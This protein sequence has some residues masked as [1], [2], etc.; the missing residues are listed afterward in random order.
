MMNGEKPVVP[1]NY[2]CALIARACSFGRK[3]PTAYENP[4]RMDSKRPLP[5]MDGYELAARLRGDLGLP[6]LPVI[7]LTGWGS[8]QDRARTTAAGF[9]AHLTKPVRPEQLFQVIDEW[10]TQLNAVSKS[11]DG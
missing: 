3:Q 8:H 11:V 1:N 10:L 7:A 6:K 2:G 9:N 4:D 5:A